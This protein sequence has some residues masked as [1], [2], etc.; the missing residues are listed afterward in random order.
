[1]KTR[2]KKEEESRE[3]S[4][5]ESDSPKKRSTRI[6][7]EQ[8]RTDT[9]GRQAARDDKR[10]NRDNRGKDDTRN[11]DDSSKVKDDTSSI[12]SRTKDDETT[13]ENGEVDGSLLTGRP[14]RRRVSELHTIIH[15]LLLSGHSYNHHTYTATV[16]AFIQPSYI[17]CYCWGIHT[18]I[19]HI[20]LLSGHSCYSGSLLDCWSTG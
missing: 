18:T 11:K 1:M 12:G 17:Y 13:S 14:P 15:I 10:D 19:I 20:L 7:V 3:E 4:D 6:S 16:G 2:S 8:Q 9:R 5:A